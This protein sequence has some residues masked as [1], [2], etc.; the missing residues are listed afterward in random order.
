MNETL[1]ITIIIIL[2]LALAIAA[3][4]YKTRKDARKQQHL[5]NDQL[6][7]IATDGALHIDRKEVFHNRIVA[8]DTTQKVLVYIKLADG[9]PVQHLVNL[10]Q[11]TNC[12]VVHIGTTFTKD[13]GKGKK[14][15]D[16]HVMFVILQLSSGKDA[17]T[18]ITF[19]SEIE[20]GAMEKMPLTQKA[21]D[22]CALLNGLLH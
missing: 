4:M 18:D 17:I 5:L 16:R 7:T 20:D 9:G 11:V 2:C 10:A 13:A 8:L 21:N 3:M 12:K 15:D 1:V 22:W 6:N 19:Y 14:G